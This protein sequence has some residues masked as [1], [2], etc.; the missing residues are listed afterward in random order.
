MPDSNSNLSTVDG[1]QATAATVAAT[2]TV[3]A[4]RKEDDTAAVAQAVAATVHREQ[5]AL[6]AA[7]AAT[8]KTLEECHTPVLKSTEPKP[9]HVCSGCLITR[10]ATI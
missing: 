1:Q 5:E 8:C 7:V 3:A 4:K 6:I 10:I 2:T 9:L